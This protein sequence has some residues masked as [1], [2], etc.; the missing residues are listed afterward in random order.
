[1]FSL[2]TLNMKLSAVLACFENIFHPAITWE[3]IPPNLFLW[4]VWNLLEIWIISFSR[5][6]KITKNLTFATNKHLR[7]MENLQNN[8]RSGVK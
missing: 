3:K 1:M 7:Y 5:E 4:F 6:Q 8:V 2:L